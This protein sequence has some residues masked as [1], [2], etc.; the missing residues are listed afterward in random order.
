MPQYYGLDLSSMCSLYSSAQILTGVFRD[1]LSRHFAD[2]GNIE[3]PDLRHL[4]WRNEARQN[5]LI[6]SVWRWD[7]TKTGHRPAILIKRN[8]YQNRRMGIGDKRQG[9]PADSLGNVHYETFWEGSHT[10]FCIGGNGAQAELLATE[11]QRELHEYG[12]LVAA[13]LGLY[14]FA[15]TEVGAAQKLEESTENLVVPVTAGYVFA[16]RWIIRQQAPRLKRVSVS[17]IL[18]Q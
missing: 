10:L 9:P 8:A 18:E 11:V 13:E 1:W 12:P 2:P 16:E 6:E 5:I 3:V 4:V 15:V 17:Y 14:R 7:P